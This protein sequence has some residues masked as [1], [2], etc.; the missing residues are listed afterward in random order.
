MDAL[1]PAPAGEEAT[2]ESENGLA[3]GPVKSRA[4]DKQTVRVAGTLF[5]RGI[6][7]ADGDFGRRFLDNLK[8]VGKP[9]AGLE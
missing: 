3:S 6:S 5:P 2:L 7:A 8:V 4:D 9:R 1:H